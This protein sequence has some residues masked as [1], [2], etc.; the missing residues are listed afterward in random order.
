VFREE[1]TWVCPILKLF[2][3]SY[4]HMSYSGLEETSS[5]LPKLPGKFAVIRDFS[6]K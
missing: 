1:T 4:L 3:L 6:T 2:R 5:L